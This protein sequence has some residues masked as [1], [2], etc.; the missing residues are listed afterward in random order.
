MSTQ[1]LR[2]RTCDRECVYDRCAPFGQGQQVAYAV[3]WRC[4]DGH[5][6]SLDVCPVGPLVPASDLCLNCGVHY[7]SDGQDA[8]CQACG[9]SRSACLTS[10]DLVEAPADP[11][12][13]A[14]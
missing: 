2:C 9:L 1:P 4:P 8:V 10:F 14:Q 11:I 7:A 5:G 12:A 6:L 13:A 3:A